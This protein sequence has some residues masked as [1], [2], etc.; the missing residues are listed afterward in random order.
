[1]WEQNN[2]TLRFR[3]NP[4]Y[5]HEQAILAS[6]GFD[7]FL[8]MTFLRSEQGLTARYECSGFTPLSS[9][10]IERTEDV[11]YLMEKVFL[12]LHRA[13]E[14]LLDPER[15]LLRTELIFYSRE[16]DDLKIAYVPRPQ[17]TGS[18]TGSGSQTRGPAT[19]FHRELILLLAQM[20]QEVCDPHGDL[21]ARLA[22]ELYYRCPDTKSMLRT[23]GL[24]RRELD[25]A[26]ESPAG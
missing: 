14:Y 3:R 4:F 15:I 25:A 19:P 7:G 1:M 16:G 12:V 6:A 10:R 11:L 26:Q 5:R 22:R 8:P 21:I 24:L 20:K 18:Q 2:Y 9:F 17:G 23:I 13:P